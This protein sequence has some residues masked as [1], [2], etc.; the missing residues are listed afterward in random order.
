VQLLLID[1]PEDAQLE[2]WEAHLREASPQDPLYEPSL[3]EWVPRLKKKKKL[4]GKPVPLELQHQNKLS[5]SNLAVNRPAQSITL[6]V[7]DVPS[8]SKD[9]EI[10]KRAGV[11][12]MA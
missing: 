12:R 8:L 10:L 3:Q 11:W 6:L 2:V 1:K 9:K 5:F 7:L 4:V